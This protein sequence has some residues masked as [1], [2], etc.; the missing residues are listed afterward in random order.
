MISYLLTVEVLSEFAKP[1]HFNFG[2]T[3]QIIVFLV[4]VFLGIFLHNSF[5]R[6]VAKCVAFFLS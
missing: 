1:E 2:T 6:I 4:T 5:N 3:F